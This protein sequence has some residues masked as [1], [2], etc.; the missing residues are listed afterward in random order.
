M[1]TQLKQVVK[2]ADAVAKSE[3]QSPAKSIPHFEKGIK[4]CGQ[5]AQ[6]M[7]LLMADVLSERVGTS[8]AN[9]VCNA[10]GKMLKAVEM[11]QRYGTT[12]KTGAKE[13][14]LIA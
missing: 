2:K 13:L 10:G 12:Q 8:T 3:S 1:S 11:Q 14:D 9:A 5:L 4:T 7:S 6:G